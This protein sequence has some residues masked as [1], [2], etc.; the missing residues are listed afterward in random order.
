MGL[1]NDQRIAKALRDA[2][3]DHEHRQVQASG[4]GDWR[5]SFEAR[6]TNIIWRTIALSLDLGIT[7]A[8][9]NPSTDPIEL[10]RR[11]ER[12]CRTALANSAPSQDKADSSHKLETVRDI[13]RGVLDGV[14]VLE[15]WTGTDSREPFFL[16]DRAVSLGQSE[17]ELVL[18]E[19]GHW[20]Q[21]A[22]WKDRKIGRPKGS[23]ANWRIQAAPLIQGWIDENTQ[24]SRDD[25]AT[26]LEEWLANNWHRLSQTRPRPPQFS[27]LE[28]I[29]RDMDR[30]GQI[31][32]NPV[33]TKGGKKIKTNRL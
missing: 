31:T 21:V 33:P 5:T 16:A 32:L 30:D 28:D 13:L 25:L 27:S 6:L 20:E 17:A 8:R 18:A 1:S 26:K 3:A 24:I 2:A 19:E 11:L 23:R 14:G 10:A 7:S 12:D 9:F 22:Q 29:L 15:S 4:I